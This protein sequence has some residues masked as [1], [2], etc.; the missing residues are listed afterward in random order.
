MVTGLAVEKIIR[1]HVLATVASDFAHS[2]QGIY[3]FF[4]KT[5]YAY[6]YDVKAIKS[7]IGKILKYLYDEE[8]IDV[9]GDEICATKFGK[10][11]SELYIDPLTGVVIRD[12]LQKQ[13][14]YPNGFRLAAFDFSHTR[15]G[16]SHET[17]RAGNR[18]AWRLQLEEHR[19]ELFTDVPNEWEDRVCLRGVSSAKSKPRWL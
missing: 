9:D 18:P 13:A 1:G 17:L 5:F 7:I 19:D 15:H 2:E 11:V 10:R 14:S 4:G 3:E 16:T 12:A 8:M 6:Q